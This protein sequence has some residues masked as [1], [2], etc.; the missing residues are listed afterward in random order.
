MS[1]QPTGAQPAQPNEVQAQTLYAL[2]NI[3]Q[4]AQAADVRVQ[5]ATDEAFRSLQ[6]ALDQSDANNRNIA[7]RL[8]IAMER[9]ESIAKKVEELET[10]TRTGQIALKEYINFLEMRLKANEETV[11]LKANEETVEILKTNLENAKVNFGKHLHHLHF[12]GYNPNKTHGP[13]FA[14]KGLSLF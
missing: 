10:L 7:E 4:T 14:G 9:I 1:L 11:R 6:E 8:C 13:S 3:H 5:Q 2:A 12:E